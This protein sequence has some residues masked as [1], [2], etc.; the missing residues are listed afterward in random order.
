LP[1]QG[2]EQVRGGMEDG[3]KQMCKAPK[4]CGDARNVRAPGTEATNWRVRVGDVV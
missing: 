4:W 1:V 2:R 3:E